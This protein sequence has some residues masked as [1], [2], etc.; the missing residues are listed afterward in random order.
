MLQYEIY[1]GEQCQRT[2][3]TVNDYSHK[4]ERSYKGY[5]IISAECSNIYFAY[6]I[7]FISTHV[8]D[9]VALIRYWKDT[10]RAGSCLK[11]NLKAKETIEDFEISDTF[12]RHRLND[13]KCICIILKLEEWQQVSDI[14]KEF[15]IT[16][17]VHD[18]ENHFKELE[19][20][21][22]LRGS[23][24]KVGRREVV[25]TK[26]ALVDI[27]LRTFPWFSSNLA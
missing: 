4:I 19:A 6:A 5:E 21:Q 11:W 7:L 27:T 24:L 23:V 1:I 18:F 26:V 3:D 10:L 2:D 15:D 20:H 12:C 17:L 25:Q 13:F 9:V 8:S 14:F 22:R 16:P